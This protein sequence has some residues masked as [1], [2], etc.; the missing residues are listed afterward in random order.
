MIVDTSAASACLELIGL[1]LYAYIEFVLKSFGIRRDAT[2]ANE[3]VRDEADSQ[4][5]TERIEKCLGTS[6]D[7][8][9]WGLRELALSEGGLLQGMC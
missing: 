6:N 7:V 2:V 9:L 3:F 8:D 1:S 5:K 4:N